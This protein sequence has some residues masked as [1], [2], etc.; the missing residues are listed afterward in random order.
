M[1]ASFLHTPAEVT[2]LC[3]ALSNYA[4]FRLA[5]GVAVVQSIVPLIGAQRRDAAWM[6]IAAPAAIAQFL[7]VAFSFAVL[8]WAFVASDFSLKVVVEN[9]HTLKPMRFLA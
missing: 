4:L 9:S 1:S 3:P 7:L 6:A 5:L 8:T 2:F